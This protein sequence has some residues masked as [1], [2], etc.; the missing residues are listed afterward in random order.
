MRSSR[1]SRGSRQSPRRRPHRRP[2]V[3]RPHRRRTCPRAGVT[4]S[5]PSPRAPSVG[6]SGARECQR[7][8]TSIV[9]HL[10]LR[11][12]PPP[13]LTQRRHGRSTRLHYPSRRPTRPDHPPSLPWPLPL[14]AHHLGLV[15][16]FQFRMLRSDPAPRL[17]REEEVSRHAPLR[18]RWG[19]PFLGS[20]AGGLGRASPRSAG[21]VRQLCGLL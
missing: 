11:R 1:A 3:R 16:H 4:G 21:R 2:R 13:Y 19:S 6:I 7:A 5:R 10:S 17:S 12:P 20:R 14:C 15:C 8:S 9:R 18:S